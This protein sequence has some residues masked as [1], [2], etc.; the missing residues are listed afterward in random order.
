MP[1]PTPTTDVTS[2]DR[3]GGVARKTFDASA[4]A[5]LFAEGR[6]V[7]ADGLRALA[8]ETG[9]RRTVRW[10]Q[11]WA[12]AV[13]SSHNVAQVAYDPLRDAPPELAA[14][15]AAAPD[16]GRSGELIER[17]LR[18][19]RLTDERRSQSSNVLWYPLVLCAA[20]AVVFGVVAGGV[21][22]EIKRTVTYFDIPSSGLELPTLLELA[23]AL[24]QTW[25]Y[26]AA[27]LLAP[28]AILFVL[29]LCG[30]RVVED[31][32]RS[33][34]PGFGL[35]RWY[36]ALA[37]G[38]RHL[39]TLVELQTPLPAAVRAAG[40]AVEHSLLTRGS[41]R[42]ADDLAAGQSLHQAL[43]SQPAVPRSIGMLIEWGEDRQALAE[44]LGLVADWCSQR[45]EAELVRV[46]TVLPLAAVLVSGGTA[47]GLLGSI[48]APMTRF[49]QML[50]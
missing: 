30:V 49:I 21:A 34:L 3:T 1:E 14:L 41:V 7:S 38:A 26:W 27:A 48:V 37:E 43:L 2:S 5:L 46:E 25:P 12:D 9:D 17:F 44:S 6:P 42:V 29:R 50:S 4:D 16:R 28:L 31:W 19:R 13:E 23:L 39:R 18:A 33:L 32:L 10:L 24:R 35:F 36:L 22:L 40:A 20:S 47:I 45:A 8:H 15:L 11:R